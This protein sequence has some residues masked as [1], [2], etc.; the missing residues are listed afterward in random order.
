ML[1]KNALQGVGTVEMA[2]YLR[3]L[4]ALIEDT[5]PIPR[6]HIVTHN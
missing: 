6:I 3:V 2:Q 4:V 1:N 5:I